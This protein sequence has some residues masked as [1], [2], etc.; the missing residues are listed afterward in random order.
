ML[1]PL[2]TKDAIVVAPA[3]GRYAVYD[4]NGYM[5]N[6][7]N[8]DD[9]GVADELGGMLRFLSFSVDHWRRLPTHDSATTREDT[10]VEIDVLANDT[11]P[12][13]G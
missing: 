12:N 2:K 8:P 11:D 3:D 6:P 10:S 7:S 13:P 9:F 1:P 4:G 5:T